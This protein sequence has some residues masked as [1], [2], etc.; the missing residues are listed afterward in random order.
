MSSQMTIHGI[1]S[2][3]ELTRSQNNGV[4]ETVTSGITKAKKTCEGDLFITCAC[5][6]CDPYVSINAK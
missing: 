4:F 2:S 6:N 5:G 3:P 1:P